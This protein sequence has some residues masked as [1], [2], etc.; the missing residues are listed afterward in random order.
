MNQLQEKGVKTHIITSIQHLKFLN[1]LIYF[2]SSQFLS[3]L[4]LG[5]S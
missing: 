1:Q 3:S 2:G 4:N 5:N